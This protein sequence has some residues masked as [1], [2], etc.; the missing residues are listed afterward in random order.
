MKKLT[1]ILLAV[2]SLN[3]HALEYLT[4]NVTESSG[5]GWKIGWYNQ[6]NNY[7]TEDHRIVQLAF[8]PYENKFS[9]FEL[10]EGQKYDFDQGA[11]VVDTVGIQHIQTNVS[12]AGASH[13][14]QYLNALKNLT[15]KAITKYNPK[16]L[17]LKYNG[18]GSGW[19]NLYGG[20]ISGREN[21][22]DY[23]QGVVDALGKKI[24][25]L[26]WNTNC[27]VLS[28][29]QLEAQADYADFFIASEFERGGF[30]FNSTFSNGSSVSFQ[31]DIL[32][33]RESNYYLSLF[34]KE[35]TPREIAEEIVTKQEAYWNFDPVKADITSRKIKQTLYLID[36]EKFRTFYRALNLPS[37]R[38]KGQDVL[39][40]VQ[41]QD[42][43]S[44]QN[45]HNMIISNTEN[46]SFF[47]WN[48]DENGVTF[49]ATG[50]GSFRSWGL[51]E[52]IV[53]ASEIGNPSLNNSA[54]NLYNAQ[55]IL[56][57]NY[58][59]NFDQLSFPK[60]SYFILNAQGKVSKKVK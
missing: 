42:P 7:S 40:V 56:I 46:K 51:G 26:D 14:D 33:L 39:E 22:Q 13:N 43:S 1:L 36:L 45:Y 17:T 12:Y 34:T 24:D 29:E 4:I 23:L 2:F 41:S 25:I 9:L 44:E 6:F 20:Y 19:A 58:R 30:N 48:S 11:Y 28:M 32:P 8:S 57:G 5:P 15:I 38:Y 35:K 47:D 60:G 50:S 18:H 54:Y 55:G 37:S 21:V 16:H 3:S 27:N 31:D 52:Q 53:F 10:E 49:D 59:N